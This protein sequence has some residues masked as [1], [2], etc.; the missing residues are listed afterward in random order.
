MKKIIRTAVI[1][2]VL[3]IAGFV[4]FLYKMSENSE[5]LKEEH[6]KSINEE[7]GIVSLQEKQFALDIPG[8]VQ[9]EDLV[10]AGAEANV[11]LFDN[12]GAIDIYTVEHSAQVK[13]Q[14]VRMQSR[15]EY[16]FKEPLLA[17][18]PYGTNACGLYIYFSTDTKCSLKYTVSVADETIP[19]FTRT[20]TESALNGK[21]AYEYFLTGLVP[22]RENYVRLK[23][24]AEDGREIENK[25]YRINMPASIYGNIS[26]VPCTYGGDVKVISNGLF[27]VYGNG[28]KSI[29]VYDNAGVLRQEIPVIKDSGIGV[30]FSN[31]GMY[32]APDYRTIVKISPAGE[33]L[34]VAK[35]GEYKLKPAWDYDGMGQ[36]VA[37]ASKTGRNTA[38]DVIIAVDMNS[39]NVSQLV[40]IKKLLKRYYNKFCKGKAKKDW[41]G[42]DSLKFFDKQD[43]IISASGISTIVKIDNVMT[44]NPYV[45]YVIGSS[46]SW[47]KAGM[48]EKLLAKGE[49]KEEE[50]EASDDT[51]ETTEASQINNI[52]EE[53]SNKGPF[54]DIN[55][56]IGL[57]PYIN[58]DG[59]PTVDEEGNHIPVSVYYLGTVSGNDGIESKYMRYKIDEETGVYTLNKSAN[60]VPVNS[61]TVSETAVNYV[62][63][64]PQQTMIYECDVNGYSYLQLA[65]SGLGVEKYSLKEY[66]FK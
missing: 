6:T 36:L 52:L 38:G 41:A 15:K 22:G 64:D 51:A 28:T 54:E 57:M 14:L 53:N 4:A 34:S 60:T 8:T 42:V 66:L 25:V 62:M 21:N 39:G 9:I 1:V 40:D 47:T 10:V 7:S 50:T 12:N 13:E 49:E 46:E 59:M 27:Y 16:T 3:M 65:V 26:Q 33:V 56:Q 18:N 23:L 55:K 58:N 44:K 32:V 30:R 63:Y 48:G 19:D 17:Y 45:R 43:V 31:A 37:V 29:A 2:S 35:T 24:M 20:M 5:K 11:L 61:G